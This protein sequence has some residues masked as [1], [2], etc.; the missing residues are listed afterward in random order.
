[1][2]EKMT[3]SFSRV[4]SFINCPAAWYQHYILKLPQGSNAY[5]EHGLFLHDIMERHAKNEITHQESLELFDNTWYDVEPDFPPFF[6]DLK[7][8]FYHKIRKYFDRD[9]ILEGK[10]I[11]VEDK[12]TAALPSGELITGLI[13]RVFEVNGKITISDYKIS[14]P[15]TKKQ[16]VTK[17]RQLDLYAFLIHSSTG[18]YP[19]FQSWSFFKDYQKT[20]TLA[21]DKDSMD[22]TIE[23]L[24]STIREING[25]LVAMDRLGLKG[26]FLPNYEDRIDSKTNERDF[27]CTGLCGYKE[28]CNFL[29]EGNKL[30]TFKP[31][32]QEIVIKKLK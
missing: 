13:D 1:M 17:R 31:Q 27:F 19:D 14:T 30:K 16:L 25:R 21:F 4:D 5:S 22:S 12:I 6:I 18:K 10:T 24:E 3:W 20:T 23:W 32:N 8:N 9:L 11:S 7:D 28:T 29:A 2:R 15:F 26:L